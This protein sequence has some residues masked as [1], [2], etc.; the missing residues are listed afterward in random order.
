[1]SVEFEPREAVNEVSKMMGIRPIALLLMLGLS[2]GL[3]VAIW[4][5]VY[6]LTDWLS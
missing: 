4:A 2:A 5:A 3:W 6:A 1:M